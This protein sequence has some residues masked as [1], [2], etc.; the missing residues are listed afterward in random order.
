MGYMC[1]RP[2]A[3]RVNKYVYK[4]RVASVEKVNA[5]VKI[6]ESTLVLSG[7]QLCSSFHNSSTSKCM[8]KTIISKKSFI[9]KY[10]AGNAYLFVNPIRS[11]CQIDARSNLSSFFLS[12]MCPSLQKIQ[13]FLDIFL[14]LDIFLSVFSLVC[15]KF[16]ASN[17]KNKV[18][19]LF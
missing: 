2:F 1:L 3:W 7:L 14:C 4:K 11:A 8:I 19:C 5:Y 10:F 6:N 15:L 17:H 16:M 9:L 13:L 12:L 18:L